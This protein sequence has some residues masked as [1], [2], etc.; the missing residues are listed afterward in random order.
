MEHFF[1]FPVPRMSIGMIQMECPMPA[2]PTQTPPQPQPLEYSLNPN[3]VEFV[4]SYRQRPEVVVAST[5]TKM[6]KTEA[7]STTTLS[8]PEIVGDA[9]EQGE[10]GFL[11]QRQIF[12]CLSQLGDEQMPLEEVA[13]GLLPGGQGLSM[14]FTTKQKA[15][16]Q[17]QPPDPNEPTFHKGHTLQLEVG[18]PKKLAS[19]PESVLV[20]QFLFRVNDL[21]REKYEDGADISICPKCTLCSNRSYTELEI[22][23]QIEGIKAFENFTF[24]ESTRYQDLVSHKAFKEL[25]RK[26]G[27][28]VSRD[29]IH[30]NRASSGLSTA[31][32][33]PPPSAQ[34]SEVTVAI[35][36]TTTETE[37]ETDADAYGGDDESQSN[38]DELTPKGSGSL[39]ISTEYVR[40]KLY[41]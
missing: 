7:T 3:A 2:H 35:D 33:P 28:I 18:D 27:L 30:I 10:N 24:T 15:G 23:H 11:V 34:P 29:Q 20:A 9:L 41:R 8:H 13:V 25:C 40:G 32:S 19:R 26:L 14:R 22:E 36:Q 4:P 12:E 16:Q 21:L 38:G 6:T 5:S 17:L 37:T 31:V 39:E 1:S